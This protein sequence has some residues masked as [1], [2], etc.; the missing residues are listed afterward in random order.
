MKNNNLAFLTITLF[1]FVSFAST[2]PG[3][4]YNKI[5]KLS[6][7]PCIEYMSEL[8]ELFKMETDDSINLTFKLNVL[9]EALKEKFHNEEF[10]WR[11]DSIMYFGVSLKLVMTVQKTG[12]CSVQGFE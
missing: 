5:Y 2:P 6:D 7:A 10:T 4:E 8:A 3:I 1:S 11:A 9:D 12:R